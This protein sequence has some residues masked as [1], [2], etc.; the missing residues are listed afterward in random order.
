MT[1]SIFAASRPRA[2]KVLCTCSERAAPAAQVH[3]KGVRLLAGEVLAQDV[4]VSAMLPD[5]DPLARANARVLSAHVLDPF[6]LLHLSPR[7]RQ[8]LLVGDP[9]SR[10]IN[11]CASFP[12][13]GGEVTAAALFADTTPATSQPWDD[14]AARTPGW[15]HRAAGL[16]APTKGPHARKP[17]MLVVCRKGGALEMFSL[18]D[19]KLAFRCT[20]ANQNKAVLEE[21]G[22]RGAGD[23]GG[24]GVR[25]GYSGLGFVFNGAV[26]WVDN[27]SPAD[28]MHWATA[29]D[30]HGLR[31]RLL[32]QECAY[33]MPLSR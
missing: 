25:D 23:A 19:M 20:G 22:E 7:N 27:V 9:A 29:L 8:V 12:H 6:I 11:V 33:G 1:A 26:V 18:P 3:P 2:L 17:A 13:K 31:L 28:D 32:S 30:P 15:M 14:Q 10:L 5:A 4:A 24:G 21:E 16:A